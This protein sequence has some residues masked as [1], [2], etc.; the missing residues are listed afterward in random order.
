MS[1]LRELVTFS[2]LVALDVDGA[3]EDATE[4]VKADVDEYAV[5]VDSPVL[6]EKLTVALDESGISELDI[7]LRD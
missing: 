4:L 1:S 6:S 7:A 3:L 2:R 5:E